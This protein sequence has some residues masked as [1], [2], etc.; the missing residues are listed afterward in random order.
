VNAQQAP[1]TN[2]KEVMGP[3]REDLDLNKDGEITLLELGE[4]TRIYGQSSESD[5]S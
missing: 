5:L 4:C 2:I 3:P 1:N